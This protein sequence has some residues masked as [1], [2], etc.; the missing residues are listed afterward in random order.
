MAAARDDPRLRARKAIMNEVVSSAGR[1][2][3]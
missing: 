3:R 2:P 1:Q